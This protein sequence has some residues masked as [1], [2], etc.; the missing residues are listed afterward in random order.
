[1]GMLAVRRRMVRLVAPVTVVIFPIGCGSGYHGE[2]SL[3]GGQDTVEVDFDHVRIPASAEVRLTAC[4]LGRCSTQPFHGPDPDSVAR[5]G[6]FVLMPHL[7]VDA[8][9]EISVRLRADS[10]LLFDGSTVAHTR[11][12]QPNGPNCEPTVWHAYVVA[13]DRTRL[14]AN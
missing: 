5:D 10:R 13:H 1:M 6:L 9:V 12:V 7:P 4:A 11:K 14:T 8:D 2:C 3:I